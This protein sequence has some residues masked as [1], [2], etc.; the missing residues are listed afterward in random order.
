[1]DFLKAFIAFTISVT[2][3]QAGIYRCSDING[4][5]EDTSS[6]TVKMIPHQTPAFILPGAI[7]RAENMS[8]KPFLIYYAI[9]PDELFMQ[10]AVNFEVSKLEE[11]CRNSAVTNFAIIRNSQFL[12]SR[13]FIICKNKQLSTVKLSRF[14]EFDRLLLA[15]QRIISEEDMTL[16]DKNPLL[17]FPVSYEKSVNA[18]IAKFPLSHPDFLY[19]FIHLLIT[20]KSLFPSDEF[21]PF[22]NVKSHGSANFVLSGLYPCQLEAKN[23]SQSEFVRAK[24]PVEEQVNPS[25]KSL[26]VMGLGANVGYGM[27][28]ERLNA[29]TGLNAVAG[30]NS[31]VGLNSITGLS[32][33]H[34]LGADTAFGTYQVAMNAI[35]SELFKEEEGKVMGFVMFEAC[36]TNRNSTFNNAYLEYTLGYYSAE[37]SLWYR[38]LNWWTLLEE[39][40]GST[41]RLLT[42]LDRE[43]S[44]I[45]NFEIQD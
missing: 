22:L 7:Q 43:S 19:G 8:Q 32:S 44:R 14:P 2:F 3:A 29:V 13:E 12:S 9:D 20:D 33:G 17:K 37:H 41:S 36:D 27:Y 28:P 38:N 42:I 10:F 18:T 25:E 4:K 34:G 35:L 26:E 45:P 21:I 39:G 16:E 23:K 1:M 31:I 24:L 15:K 40:K 11:S 30:L 5:P 6:G